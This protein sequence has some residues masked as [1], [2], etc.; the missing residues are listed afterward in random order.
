MLKAWRQN[1][2]RRGIKRRL[3]VQKQWIYQTGMQHGISNWISLVLFRTLLLLS[4]FRPSC[5]YFE[6][7]LRFNIQN[8]NIYSP[9][10]WYNSNRFKNMYMYLLFTPPP[11]SVK[12]TYPPHALNDVL[13]VGFWFVNGFHFFSGL[14]FLGLSYLDEFIWRIYIAIDKFTQVYVKG[15]KVFDI[16]TVY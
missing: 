11:T 7:K 10:T 16:Y 2:A 15:K 1:D 9:F 14:H 13:H 12:K 4:G 5:L 3:R 6:N 8:S